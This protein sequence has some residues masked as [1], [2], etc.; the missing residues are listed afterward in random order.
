MTTLKLTPQ[1]SASVLHKL[2]GLSHAESSVIV[3]AGTGRIGLRSY[4][5]SIDAEDSLNCPCGEEARSVQHI[6]L[7]CP[8]FEELRQ[9]I[10]ET[11]RGTDLKTLL[12]S[13]E[14]AKQEAQFLINTRLLHNF[15]TLTHLQQRKRPLTLTLERQKLKTFG[16]RLTGKNSKTI[17]KLTRSPIRS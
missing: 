6:L 7:C 14:L 4:P 15:L 8:E 9:I 1:P 10:L 12:G 16:N 13:W 5:H 2:N 11:R 17:A 3:Q